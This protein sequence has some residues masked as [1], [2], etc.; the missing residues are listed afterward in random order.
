MNALWKQLRTW[1]ASL[2]NT[3]F[4]RLQPVRPNYAIRIEDDEHLPKQLSSHTVYIIGISGNECLAKLVCPCGCGNTLFLNLLQ[5]ESPNWKWR[6]G[7]NGT[8][9]L[10][11]SVWRKIG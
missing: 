1:G 8:V 9:T 4:R 5:D 2:W 10:Y 3:L 11:P 6:I 7:E